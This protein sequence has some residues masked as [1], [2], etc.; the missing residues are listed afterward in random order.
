[1][2]CLFVAWGIFFIYCLVRFRK[3]A[4]YQASY[5]SATSK[6][7]KYAEVFVVLFEVFLL[8]G[9]SFPVWS[10]YKTG[11]PNEN[12][13]FVVRIVAQQFV[14]NI[15]YP[16]EDKK[17]GRVDVKLMSDSNPL[18]IDATDP[19]SWDDVVAI[20]QFH[21]PVHQPVITHL[22]SKD[23]I[24][25]FGV[26]VLRVKQD[27]IPGMVVPIWFEATQTGTFDIACS[28]LCGVGHALMKGTLSV[29]NPEDF[30]KWWDA[31]PK[32]FKPKTETPKVS[33]DS[34][35]TEKNEGNSVI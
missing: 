27:N 9:L 13:S 4:G 19:A 14:W 15:H 20:N 26:P 21:L 28:Q 11:F 3:R 6:L 32:P 1:M 5:V 31:Q 7:P 10:K 2:I 29:D 8:V 17:F 16:G 33:K 25:S 30:Q 12:D 18:G 23:V 35:L 34:F 24:H 22:S